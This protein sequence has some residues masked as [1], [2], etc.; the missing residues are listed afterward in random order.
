[1]RRQNLVLLLSSAM[2]AALFDD[3][4]IQLTL[5]TRLNA[6]QPIPR[7]LKPYALRFELRG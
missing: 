7:T 1:M 2:L 4:Q 3:R 5:P 6:Q